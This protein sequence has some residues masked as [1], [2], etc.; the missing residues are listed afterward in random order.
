M[1]ISEARSQKS[2]K[3]K[4]R[5]FDSNTKIESFE[6]GRQENKLHNLMSVARTR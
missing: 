2:L 6:I 4:E 1:S 5:L 3:S